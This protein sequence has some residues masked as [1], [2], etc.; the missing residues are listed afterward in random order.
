[1]INDI[2]PWV[3]FWKIK[4]NLLI[5]KFDIKWLLCK[6]T[7]IPPKPIIPEQIM[8]FIWSGNV[9]SLISKIPLVI[10]KNPHRTDSTT[11]KLQP[12]Y[13][14]KIIADSIE[15]CKK[16]GYQLF[17]EDKECPICKTKRN[18]NKEQ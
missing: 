18:Q 10:S 15:L 7:L 2:D 8:V 13:K 16:C 5:C 6:N 9:I 17:E 4:C 11:S 12:T 3:I 1:M 14:G